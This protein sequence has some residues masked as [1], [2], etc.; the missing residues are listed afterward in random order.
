MILERGGVQDNSTLA[1]PVETTAPDTAG[2]ITV[3]GGA[4][5][6][7]TS[8]DDAW[9][10][11]AA[12]TANVTVTLTAGTYEASGQ[13]AYS[14][15][16][17][18]KITGDTSAE[19]GTNV[20]IHGNMNTNAQNS[21]EL[22][23]LTKESTGNLTLEYITL[24]SDYA[25]TAA[26]DV[27]SEVLATAGTGNVAAYNC[28]FLSGQDTI[29]TVAK[30]F[31]YKC[32]IEGDVDFL[33][34]EKTG[35]AALY[36]ECTIR[37]VNDRVAS[38]YFTAPRAELTTRV[39]KGLV[40]YN[41]ALQVESGVTAYLGRNPWS[42]SLSSQ[43]N[44]VAVVNSKTTLASGATLDSG[45]WKSN[46][47]GTSD[48]QYIGFKTDDT[49]SLPSNGYGAVLSSSVKSAEYAGRN[50]ILNRVYNKASS[51]FQKDIVTEWDIASV[52]SSNG[53]TCTDDSS[54]SLLSGETEPSLVT[55]DLTSETL[56]DDL[57]FSSFTH[58]GSGSVYGAGAAAITVP[59]KGNAVVTV[60]GFYSGYGTIKAG[61]Q[62]EGVYDFNNNKT[63]ATVEKSYVNYSGAC[64]LVI[65][66]STASYI[67][68]IEVEY[69]DAITYSP[70]TAISVTSSSSSYT[71]GV[72]AT[73]TA[74]VSPDTATNTDVKWT[75]SDET[76]GTINEF[77]GTAAFLKEGSVTF[78]AAA[79]DGS[80]V[81]GTITCAP[82]AAE[83][84]SA[85][86]YN[87]YDNSS[88]TTSGGGTSLDST[89]N[90]GTNNNIFTIGT[91]SGVTLGS[92]KSVTLIDGT[93]AS[94][95]T[96]LKM[97]SS[98]TVT[99]SVT[100]SAK[101][102]VY[103]GYCSGSNKTSDTLG[104]KSSDGTATADRS[105]PTET[106]AADAV[107]IWTLTAGTYTVGRAASGYA[108][109]IYYIR[110]NME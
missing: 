19:Y 53:W 88:K 63:S 13:L 103:T 99:F 74:A 9:A 97:N 36:E 100:D 26:S 5:Y 17:D 78:T 18:I 46:S 61:E 104:I 73:M 37:A 49:Y 28:S 7:G 98:G 82:E 96:G 10:Q 90:S 106:P 54:L 62:G 71:V 110:V 40:I 44:Q 43:Y 22:L 77:T 58:H 67:T 68:K 70:V 50:N 11:V 84:E 64:N 12:A 29:R 75:S 107:Y 27:Q 16:Y 30:A 76:V 34:M 38:A 39:G 15:A 41:S 72:A 57:T 86:W 105:N 51:K 14:G 3:T 94:I 95:S 25:F 81:T 102:T 93:T 59:L 80:G 31:F 1:D 6:S 45:L 42:S 47:Y 35:T 4:T 21:R 33:W 60:S 108:P 79:R 48:K 2:T 83:W 23:F 85:E 24:K 91:S 92:V 66:A 32:Y 52:I 65:T 56:P 8:I 55:Y 20:L 109:S 101:V 87:A 89:K 69:D